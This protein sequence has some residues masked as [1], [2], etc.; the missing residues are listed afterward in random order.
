MEDDYIKTA[1]KSGTTAYLPPEVFLGG[2][3]KGKP[4]DIWASGITL[5]Q[6]VYGIHPFYQGKADDLT[7]QITSAR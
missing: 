6:M 7:K 1:Q 4:L 5:F 2:V 3:V